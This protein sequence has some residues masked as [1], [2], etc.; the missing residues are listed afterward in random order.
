VNKHGNF[1]N[2]YKAD[3][4]RDLDPEQKETFPETLALLTERLKVWLQGP[5]PGWI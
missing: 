1:V 3:F 4:Q 5:S 2:E